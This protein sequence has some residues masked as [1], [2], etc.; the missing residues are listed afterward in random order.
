MFYLLIFICLFWLFMHIFI[1]SVWFSF[2]VQ[3]I[4]ESKKS[5][6]YLEEHTNILLL[7]LLQ[8]ILCILCKICRFTWPFICGGGAENVCKSL[9][10]FDWTAKTKY[11]LFAKS[12]ILLDITHW[13]QHATWWGDV[14]TVCMFEISLAIVLKHSVYYAV[15]S[16]LVCHHKHSHEEKEREQGWVSMFNERGDVKPT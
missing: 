16:K 14:T 8:Y 4:C 7:L 9:W 3:S 12:L 11:I 10:L 5:V 6:L 15:C 2:C 1:Y 13:I